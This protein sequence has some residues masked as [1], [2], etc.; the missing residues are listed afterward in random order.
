MCQRLHPSYTPLSRT[1]PA[2][3]A[4]SK[5]LTQAVGTVG[6]YW[7]SIVHLCMQAPS[8][9]DDALAEYERQRAEARARA[10]PASPDTLSDLFTAMGAADGAM[11]MTQWTR[12]IK[13]T[14]W[15]ASL[16]CVLLLLLVMHSAMR[17]LWVVAQHCEKRN[18]LLPPLSRHA[19]TP[20]LVVC[21]SVRHGAPHPPSPCVCSLAR[22]RRLRAY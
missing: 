5:L 12:R 9:V 15:Y 7:L 8:P 2:V 4:F 11:A 1:R 14:T 3:P 19:A 17:S 20:C 13:G 10:L 21:L 16:A 6:N 22:R 18:G